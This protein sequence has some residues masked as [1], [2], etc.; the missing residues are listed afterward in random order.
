MPPK[1]AKAEPLRRKK[2]APREVAAEEEELPRGS[3]S[4]DG[5]PVPAG[6]APGGRRRKRTEAGSAADEVD[7]TK[8]ARHVGPRSVPPLRAE[9]LSP[10]SR[11]LG[12]I[13]AVRRRKLVVVL[14]GGL[15]G[16]VAFSE[17]SDALAAGLTHPPDEEDEEGEDDSNDEE[18]EF[19]YEDEQSARTREKD[20]TPPK[21]KASTQP[22]A[23]LRDLFAPGQRVRC[24]VL[25][26]PQRKYNR[27]L[28]LSLRLSRVQ[29]SLLRD[30][31]YPG[32]R[33]AA[34]IRSVEDYGYVL[35]LGVPTVT[36]FLRSNAQYRSGSLLNVAV[37]SFDSELSVVTAVEDDGS[38][39]QESLKEYEGLTLSQLMPGALVAASVRN[40][41]SNGL[42]L[43][44][45]THLTG[46]VELSHLREA[47]PSSNWAER[48]EERQKVNARVLFV[49]SKRKRVH[50]SLKPH[51][52]NAT[53]VD[54]LPIGTVIEHSIVRR[55]DPNGGLL[56]ELP[57]TSKEE[58]LPIMRSSVGYVHAPNV[59]DGH[60]ERLERS[61]KEGQPLKA[62]VIGRKPIEGAS[63]LSLKKSVVEQRFFSLSEIVHG[64]VI[65]GTLERVDSKSGAFIKISEN[66]TALCP[67]LHLTDSNSQR[68]LA[69]LEPGKKLK[70]RVLEIN[71]EERKLIVTRK[72]QLLRSDLPILA[73][74]EDAA[75]GTISHGVITGVFRYGCFV[76]FY[77]GV[78]GLAHANDL[79]LGA[80]QD[81]RES[82]E[83][84]QCARCTVLSA[85]EGK[86]KLRLSL[87]GI[88]NKALSEST[89][90]ATQDQVEVGSMLRGV[91]EAPP[92]R[93]EL[94][95][96]LE[97]GARGVMQVVH[98]SDHLATANALGD[99]I[100]GDEDLGQ[101]L[102]INRGQR[103]G[104]ECLY[105][106]K[107]RLLMKDMSQ[108]K[109]PESIS[110]LNEGETYEGYIANITD[111]GC[112]VRFLGNLTGLASISASNT[113]NIHSGTYAIGQ[114][115]QAR[116]TSIEREKAKFYLTLDPKRMRVDKCSSELL[117][118]ML[119]GKELLQRNEGHE[120][121]SNHFA[122][123]FKVNIVVTEEKDYGLLADLPGYDSAVGFIMH[124]Q[125]RP[126][127][128]TLYFRC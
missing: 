126:R 94:N 104:R 105:L 9:A 125:V 56:L 69:K 30:A 117:V 93:G 40:V 118:D 44:F 11:V 14:P 98:L 32:Y 52:V 101:L 100:A 48:Y 110:D 63:S 67:P 78:K 81:P 95:V 99:S 122:I 15:R 39:K 17:A 112:F 38:G 86:E 68:A 1:P 76:S 49:D 61:F 18:D 29:G 114:S 82:Y 19:V 5:A 128:L 24:V 107:K 77:N 2:S 106:T 59:S 83:R 111:I 6:A 89:P 51:I 88:S 16:S 7:P 116:V 96:R 55:V 43:S 66:I 28:Q 64:A 127:V 31:F 34:T 33:V 80:G 58:D 103:N 119:S 124:H 20:S 3:S 113:G 120:Q 70:V 50:L 10:G 12:E 57:S 21:A 109:L 53:N 22:L 79:G 35:S 92:A 73:S 123:G 90:Q 8:R 84:G 75:P 62:R 115:V 42:I 74:L 25:S 54:F 85:S 47:F 26:N 41:V 4:S 71:P 46:Y 97:N 108:S 87:I 36:G 72:R 60:I 102:V 91:A 45:L 121:L 65:T 37:E 13:V 27:N 23:S